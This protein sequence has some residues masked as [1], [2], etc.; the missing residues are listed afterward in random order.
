M[1]IPCLMIPK[2]QSVLDE[3]RAQILKGRDYLLLDND[4]KILKSLIIFT[5]IDVTNDHFEWLHCSKAKSLA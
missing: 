5:Q 3:H 4:S 2:F 1:I